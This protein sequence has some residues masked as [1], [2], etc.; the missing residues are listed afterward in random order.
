M[1]KVIRGVRQ[2]PKQTYRR[3]PVLLGFTRERGNSWEGASGT[4]NHGDFIMQA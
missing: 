1:E 2:K 4:E 3:C